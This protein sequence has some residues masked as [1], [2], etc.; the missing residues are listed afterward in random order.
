MRKNPSK[1]SFNSVLSLEPLLNFWRKNVVPSCSHMAAMFEVFESRL[2]EI[3]HLRGD[4]EDISVLKKHQDLLVPLMSVIF[5]AASWNHEVAGALV[6]YTS[7]T[8][9]VS[10]KFEKLLIDEE[11]G[12]KGGGDEPYRR[13]TDFAL[14]AYYLI[15]D[16]IYGIRQ[17]LDSAVIHIAPDPDTGLNRYFRATPDLQFTDVRSLG[18]PP[19]LTQE[20]RT[21][22]MENITDLET[23][24]T[25]IQP[26]KFQF[27]GFMVIRAVDVTES[28]V[29]S[30]LEED[31]IDQQS[32]FSADGF[33]RLQDRLRTLFR[34]PELIA[35]LGAIKGDHVL[36]LTDGCEMEANCIFSNSSHIPLSEIEGSVWLRAVEQKMVLRIPDLKV[37]PDLTPIERLVLESGARS[38]LISPSLLPG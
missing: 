36:V 30:S 23:L 12:L 18:E 19:R 13:E 17:K 14:R 28:E 15:L 33:G 2:N 21:A 26:E 7:Q 1:H 37:E 8:F 10:P 24:A 4:I 5:P 29:L 32:I 27:S 9:Y 11:G 22:I 35:G 38:L 25:F 3:P 34:R 31:L 20:D 16:R 6:P